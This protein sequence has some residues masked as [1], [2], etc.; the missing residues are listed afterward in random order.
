MKTRL[1]VIIF[2]LLSVN[3]FCQTEQQTK[4]YLQ[5]IVNSCPP[6]SNYGNYLFT[7]ATILKID[8]ENFGRFKMTDEEFPFMLMYFREYGAFFSITEVVDIRQITA[9]DVIQQSDKN[10]MYYEV[11]IYTEENAVG[12][13][14]KKVKPGSSFE[15]RTYDYSGKELSKMTI[16]LCNN[17][18]KAI[19]IKKGRIHLCKLKGV[20]VKDGLF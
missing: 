16:M 7:D 17:Q 8:A 15:N 19:K 18:E 12:Q 10:N 13:T 2:L 5:D 1:T 14:E 3:V 20:N 11:Q 6:T 9:I 4:K